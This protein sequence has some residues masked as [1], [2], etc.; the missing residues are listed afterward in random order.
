[1]LMAQ[2]AADYTSLTVEHTDIWNSDYIPFEAK[3]YPCIGVYEASQNPA[4]HRTIDTLE[5]ID[6]AHLS[7]V[8]KMVVATLYLLAR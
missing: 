4:Y 2:A 6:M 3:G 5:Q 8:A 7:E 1:M